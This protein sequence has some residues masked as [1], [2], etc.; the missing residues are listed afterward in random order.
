MASEKVLPLSTEEDMEKTALRKLLFF[1]LA[2]PEKRSN[3]DVATYLKLIAKFQVH[4]DVTIGFNEKEA[5][6]VAKALNLKASGKG[7]KLI[8]DLA[9]KIRKALDIHTCVIHPTAYA[10]AVDN[11]GVNAV[12]AGPYTANPKTSLGAG[13][14]FNAG[15]CIGRLLG[16]DLSQSLQL[17]VATSGFFVRQAISPSREQLVRFLQTL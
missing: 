2:D 6:Q 12:V 5:L 14:H 9:T 7:E 16:C 3:E 8:L 11:Q 1:D 4:H 17:G 13:D 10:V 15:Y